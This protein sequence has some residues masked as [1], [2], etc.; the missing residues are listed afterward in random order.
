MSV[1]S[2]PIESPN[3]SAVVLSCSKGLFNSAMSSL[4]NETD[5]VLKIFDLIRSICLL[6]PSEDFVKEYKGESLLYAN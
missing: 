2:S 4:P 5:I 1:D 6:L 3:C